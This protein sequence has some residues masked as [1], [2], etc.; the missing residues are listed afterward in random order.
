MVL[1]KAVLKVLSQHSTGETH[2]QS[3]LGDRRREVR[4]PCRDSADV[5][6]LDDLGAS[7]KAT[8]VDISRS[9]LRIQ[10]GVHLAKESH[11]EIVIH[12]HAIIFGEV[13]YCRTYGEGFHLGILIEQVFYSNAHHADH[14]SDEQ[15]RLYLSGDG[16]SAREALTVAQ[17]VRVCRSCSTRMDDAMSLSESV[18]RGRLTRR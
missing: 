2:S 15:L 4:Y 11:V 17:H 9:G 13:R 10:V 18:G 14:L 6:S 1:G 8:V 7:H 16:L 5:R 3:A 12:K